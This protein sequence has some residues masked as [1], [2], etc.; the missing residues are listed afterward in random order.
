MFE[1]RQ[2]VPLQPL[3]TVIVCWWPRCVQVGRRLLLPACTH[4]G[5]QHR[6]SITRGCIDTICLS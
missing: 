2:I 6:L 3:V 1:E 5:H 4:L